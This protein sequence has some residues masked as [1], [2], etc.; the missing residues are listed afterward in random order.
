MDI[1]KQNKIN[2]IFLIFL[3]T[4]LTGN[5]LVEA[6]Y[7][8]PDDLLF[9]FTSDAMEYFITGVIGI[10]LIYVILPKEGL[11]RKILIVLCF[12]VLLF[13]LAY[14]KA[15]RRDFVNFP[16]I[17]DQFFSFLGLSSLF[18]SIIYIFKNLRYFVSNNVYETEIALQEAEYQIS[19]QQ[20]D[21]HFMFNMFNSL[22]SMSLQQHPKL[23]DTI[24]KMSNLMRY[25]TDQGHQL[26]VP[27][28]REV[29]FLEDYVALQLTRFGENSNIT[30]D[31]S[32]EYDDLFIAPLLMMTV[33]ENAFKHGYYMNSED[34]YVHIKVIIK[35]EEIEL[36]SKNSI[37]PKQHFQDT[38]REGSG[39]KH[40]R[41]RLKLTYPQK[42]D[43]QIQE[44]NNEFIVS[45][46]IDLD[47]NV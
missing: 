1:S 47:E 41:K 23:S 13:S 43:F 26:K 27:I 38:E 44:N 39:L 8:L 5:L 10:T 3:V 7:S 35:E 42:H 18:Y 29:K 46:K 24:L 11:K 14:L 32:G 20:F 34:N 31:I 30:F 40:L 15:Y 4:I 2:K 36:I 28:S 17:S 37:N 25:I 21:P 12:L 9:W 19:R 16:Y 22:Y 33:I 45:L 6:F